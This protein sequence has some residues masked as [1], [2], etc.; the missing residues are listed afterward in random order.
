MIFRSTPIFAPDGFASTRQRLDLGAGYRSAF[1]T[2][3]TGEHSP[4]SRQAKTE[5]DNANT[6]YNHNHEGYDD[7]LVHSHGW[8]VSK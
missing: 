6:Y 3:V 2:A 4:A 5:G 1:A 8:A 7:G